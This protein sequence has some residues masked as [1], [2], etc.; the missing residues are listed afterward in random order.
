MA[1][2]INDLA[3]GIPEFLVDCTEED[4][5]RLLRICREVT[6]PSVYKTIKSSLKSVGWVLIVSVPVAILI[7][8]IIN[9]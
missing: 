6:K 7:Q 5:E 8:P 9:W 3:Y 4:R 2:N 1:M